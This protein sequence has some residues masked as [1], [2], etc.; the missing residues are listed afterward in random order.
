MARE[1]EVS[2]MRVGVPEHGE[3]CGQFSTESLGAEHQVGGQTVIIMM[4]ACG[5]V[6]MRKLNS[7][8]NAANHETPGSRP[9]E[10]SNML[11]ETLLPPIESRLSG[12]TN[13]RVEY[14]ESATA[15]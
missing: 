5:Y 7:V 15:P 3:E 13:Q 4:Q 6:S 1:V 11:T 8:K 9:I 14:V 2:V 12:Q 10:Y